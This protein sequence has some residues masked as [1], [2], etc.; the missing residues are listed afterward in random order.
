M[1][2][3]AV[4]AAESLP[5]F[6]SSVVVAKVP[7]APSRPPGVL[8]GGRHLSGLMPERTVH[9]EGAARRPPLSSSSAMDLA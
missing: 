3:A 8:E 4:D 2:A 5:I 9:T 6:H 7:D 1:T